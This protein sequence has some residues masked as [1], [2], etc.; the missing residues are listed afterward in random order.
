MVWPETGSDRE[1][2]S[3]PLAQTHPKPPQAEMS[4]LLATS[5]LAAASLASPQ[6]PAA[7]PP[8]IFFILVDDL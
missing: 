5:A 3:M 7:G 6:A 8:H 4:S 2:P 1:F